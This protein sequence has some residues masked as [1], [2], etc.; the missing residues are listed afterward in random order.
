MVID[1]AFA[2]KSGSRPKQGTGTSVLAADVYLSKMVCNISCVDSLL[3]LHSQP[4]MYNMLLDMGGI[5][6]YDHQE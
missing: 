1:A 4:A 2:R 6:S 5:C 3:S